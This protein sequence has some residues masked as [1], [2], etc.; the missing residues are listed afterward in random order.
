MKLLSVLV[1]GRI[2]WE[3][4]GKVYILNV[5]EMVNWDKV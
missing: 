3:L 4:N 1:I 2:N 5:M